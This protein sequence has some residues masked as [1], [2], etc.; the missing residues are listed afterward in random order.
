MSILGS[1]NR[2][3]RA[4]TECDLDR[5]RVP[6]PFTVLTNCPVGGEP[7]RARRVEDRHAR[8]TPLVL[9]GSVHAFLASRVVG[10]VRQ[11]QERIRLPEVV[12][13][14]TEQLAITPREGAG[15]DQLESLAQFGV[16]LETARRTVALA[17][18]PLHLLGG[19]P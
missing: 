4:V 8:P 1:A 18:H 19:Q 16:T 10:V 3:S 13:E 7:S 14:R 12:G 5:P 2:D 15:V 11:H 6:Y 17:L 9:P